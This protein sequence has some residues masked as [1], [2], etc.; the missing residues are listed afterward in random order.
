MLTENRLG[1]Q[2]QKPEFG[3]DCCAVGGSPGE[4]AAGTRC[5]VES[6][7]VQAD[8]LKFSARAAQTTIP[9]ACAG[10]VIKPIRRKRYEGCSIAEPMKAL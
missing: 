10:D 2:R 6:C 4:G 3:P 5:G 8:E 1:M 9:T 7:C